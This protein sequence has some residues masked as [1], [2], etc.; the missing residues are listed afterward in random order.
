M[1]GQARTYAAGRLPPVAPINAYQCHT[2][3][4]QDPTIVAQIQR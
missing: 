4:I 2:P 1:S 3:K